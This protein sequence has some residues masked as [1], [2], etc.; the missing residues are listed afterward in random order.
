MPGQVKQPQEQGSDSWLSQ[1]PTPSRLHMRNGRPQLTAPIDRLDAVSFNTSM[2]SESGN[3]WALESSIY[4]VSRGF[5][6]CMAC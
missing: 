3:D 5:L 6:W 2:T 1:N 4:R